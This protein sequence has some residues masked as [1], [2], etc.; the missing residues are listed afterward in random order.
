MRVREEISGSRR[1]R[2][3]AHC[4]S[5]NET[6]PPL[7]ID[8]D[9]MLALPIAFER[10]EPIGGRY[11]KVFQAARVVQKTQLPQRNGLNIRRQLAARRPPQTV[12]VSSSRKL[13]IMSEYNVER[14][15]LQAPQRR[16][17][18]RSNA[19]PLSTF[20]RIGARQSFGGRAQRR[21]QSFCPGACP[22]QSP[23]RRIMIRIE[24]EY[25]GA[26][27]IRFWIVPRTSA[28]RTRPCRT[29]R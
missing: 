22:G 26:A 5:P 9:R 25:F 6:N 15:A 16:R 2:H 14:Y 23:T 18:G 13:T 19:P 1:F 11:A 7:L 3:R 27:W 24:E 4:L 8:A 12:A 29:R 17:V 28:C 10:F 20:E 21:R